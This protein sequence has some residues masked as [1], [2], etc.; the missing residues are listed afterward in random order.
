MTRHRSSES[1]LASLL[2]LHGRVA[3]VAGAAG[4]IGSAICARLVE[5]GATVYGLDRPGT[6]TPPDTTPLA[7]DL[8]DEAA[9]TAALARIDRSSGRLDV[10]VH[11]A[12]I[13][14]DARVWKTNALDWNLVL[15]T[16]LTSAFHLLHAA[17]PIM[18]RASTGSGEDAA[19]LLPGGA[20]VLI[21]SIN[22]ERAKV[23][24]S[25]YSASKAGLNALARTAARELGGFG[26][27]V[28]AVAPGWIQ[29]PMTEAVPDE[30]R[31]RAVDESALGRLGQPDDVARA[32]VFLVSEFGR[33]ITGQVLRVDGGQLMAG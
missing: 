24:L 33:H 26:I 6:A 28:N 7:C 25:S 30:F 13:T 17:V 1:G 29:S 2:N 11:A 32:V 12:G 18:R 9:V 5:C 27:R 21:S 15:A 23:G 20:I 8:T 31:Q 10:V 3:A 4:A 14:R 22:G 19:G 16:N